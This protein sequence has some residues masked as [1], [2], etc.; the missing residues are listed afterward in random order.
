MDFVG[1]EVKRGQPLLEIYS[2]ELVAT[3]EELLLAARYR[4]STEESPFEDVRDRVLADWQDEER[5]RLNDEYFTRLA[6]RYEITIEE[7][8]EPDERSESGL[9]AV[10][11]GAVRP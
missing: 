7:P 4:K 3:Q 9:A 5:T 10:P 2:P 6:E 1:Q 8:D 11:A